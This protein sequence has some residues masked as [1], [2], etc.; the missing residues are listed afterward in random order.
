MQIMRPSIVHQKNAFNI[1][2]KLRLLPK[3]IVSFLALSKRGREKVIKFKLGK[4]CHNDAVN[5][6]YCL[7]A[8]K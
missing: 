4:S 3:K 7:S 8:P 2:E 5:R 1:T 6:D